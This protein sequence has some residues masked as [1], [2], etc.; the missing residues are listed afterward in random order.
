M[1]IAQKFKRGVKLVLHDVRI[2]S[3]IMDAVGNELGV[4]RL[5]HS[6]FAAG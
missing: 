5:I 1:P 4:P 6:Y 2:G 3:G